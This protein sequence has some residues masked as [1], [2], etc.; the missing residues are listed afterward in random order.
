MSD[1]I[2]AFCFYSSTPGLHG[3]RGYPWDGGT[4]YPMT[5]G[6]VGERLTQGG[7]AICY[8]RIPGAG[9]QIHASNGLCKE[10]IRSWD[11]GTC[12]PMT[13]GIAGEKLTQGETTICY[14]RIPGD[15]HKLTISIFCRK[16]AVD[17]SNRGIGIYV[18]P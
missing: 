15:S 9:N 16:S 17:F 5:L 11:G 1:F 2:P 4:C 8:P 18:S 12:Y 3:K 6:I 14:P 10:E 13:L 7:T